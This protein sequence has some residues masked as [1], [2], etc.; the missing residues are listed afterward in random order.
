MLRNISRHVSLTRASA[1][2][3]HGVSRRA[4]AAEECGTEPD[5]HQCLARQPLRIAALALLLSSSTVAAETSEVRFGGWREI[6]RVGP[7]PPWH[8][9]GATRVRHALRKIRGRSETRVAMATLHALWRFLPLISCTTVPDNEQ[10]V[11]TH[12]NVVDL[13]QHG[14]EDISVLHF[15]IIECRRPM[16]NDLIRGKRQ[17][18][19]PAFRDPAAAIFKFFQC[20]L[21]SLSEV[22]SS[23]STKSSAYA[24][25][26]PKTPPARKESYAS[27]FLCF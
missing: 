1:L 7:C 25:S 9:D 12:G 22:L 10:R 23:S 3:T 8:R 4:T 24:C 26:L 13:F 2:T 20:S 17:I 19:S 11:G 27:S 18:N 6:V 5:W 16:E 14:L 15:E 21:V